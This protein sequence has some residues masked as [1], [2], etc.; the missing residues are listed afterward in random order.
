MDA[1]ELSI[2]GAAPDA[3][4]LSE[5]TRPVPPAQRTWSTRHFALMWT[6]MSQCIPA[7]L[8]ASGLIAVGMNW[9]QALITVALANLLVLIPLLLNSHAG[10]KYGIGF[11]V[12]TRAVFGMRGAHFAGL[13]RGLVACGW[14]G[15][16][17]WIGGQAIY[18]IV[19]QLAGRGW[20][21]AGRLGDYPWTQWLCFAVF[22]LLQLFVVWRGMQALRRFEVFAAPLLTLTFAALLVWMLIRAGGVGPILSQPSKLGWGAE[23]WAVFPPSLMSMLAFWATMSLNMP[24]FSRF[25]KNQRAQGLGQALGL[26][27]AMTWISLVS[28]AVTSASAVVYGAPI[29]D[30]V[31]LAARFDNPVAVILGLLVALLGTMSATIAS[32]VVSP[33]YVFA[34]AAPR[35]IGFRTGAVIASV[36]AV[37][38]QPWRLLADPNIYIYTWL[39]FY[40]GL[41]ASV[42]GVLIAGYWLLA[43]TEL[44][45]PDL[46]RGAGGRYWYRGGWNWRAVL[47]AVLAAV[48]SVGGAY[49][50]PGKGPFP[51]DGLIP[52]LRPLYDYSTG[53]GLVAGLVIAVL[54]APPNSRK[55]GL[56]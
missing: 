3:R 36:I 53:I 33:S 46:F 24:D 19:G 15:I 51:V 45:V 5:D 7:Y 41:V 13:A 39:G 14:F 37:V 50:D 55:R 28:I 6:S 35:F 44:H 16:Q 31:E 48:L 17:T 25:A 42:A 52:F 12:Y 9:V 43:R 23:F 2:E 20:T 40:G 47:A 10:T 8:L 54:L 22:M 26:P 21:Q 18:V 27:T 34:N 38:I 30:P 49:S 11:P 29:W 4:Y 1:A 32:D 56:Q